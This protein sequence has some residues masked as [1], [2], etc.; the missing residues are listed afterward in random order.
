MHFDHPRHIYNFKNFDNLYKEMKIFIKFF[1][2]ATFIGPFIEKNLSF[3]TIITIICS[4]LVHVTRVLTTIVN[5]H[6]V[7]Y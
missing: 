5:G 2:N 3:L 6:F 7:I 1:K 4:V